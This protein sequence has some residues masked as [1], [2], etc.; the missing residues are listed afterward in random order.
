VLYVQNRLGFW[1]ADGEETQW[2]FTKKRIGQSVLPVS[3]QKCTGIFERMVLKL[4]GNFSIPSRAP[5]EDLK[6]PLESLGFLD[7]DRLFRHE[8]RIFYD[9]EI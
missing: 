3:D 7:V 1:V 8:K 2:V 4:A 5:N 9:R 6:T